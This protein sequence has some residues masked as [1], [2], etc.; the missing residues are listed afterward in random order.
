MLER[1]LCHNILGINHSH[2]CNRR[3][4][5]FYLQLIFFL[6]VRKYFKTNTSVFVMTNKSIKLAAPSPEHGGNEPVPPPFSI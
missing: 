5:L 6:T 3:F 4:L 1:I 2:F